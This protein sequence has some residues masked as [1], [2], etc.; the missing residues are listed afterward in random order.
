MKLRDKDRLLLQGIF[1]SLT[2]PAEV[3]LFG[4]RVQ[5]TAHEGS[6]VDLVIC[7][8]TGKPLPKSEFSRLFTLLQESNL[9]LPFNLFDYA[10]LPAAFKTQINRTHEVLY[11]N[12]EAAARK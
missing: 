5:G 1:A 3:W 7:T 12:V 10:L 8:T 2:V 6:D 11:S 9:P 4:S